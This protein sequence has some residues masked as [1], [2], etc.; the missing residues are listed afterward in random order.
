MTWTKY[1][2]FQKVRAVFRNTKHLTVHGTLVLKGFS[3]SGL[4]FTR[5]FPDNHHS[6]PT[7]R[8]LSRASVIFLVLILLRNLVQPQTHLRLLRNGMILHG[9]QMTQCWQQ[10]IPGSAKKHHYSKHWTP[11]WGKNLVCSKAMLDRGPQWT[12]TTRLVHGILN[13]DVP[14]W[15]MCIPSLP[16]PKSRAGLDLRWE[17]PDHIESICPFGNWTLH[18][19]GKFNLKEIPVRNWDKTPLNTT[20]LRSWRPLRWGSATE[21]QSQVMTFITY[22]WKQAQ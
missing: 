5:E 6:C 11:N 8:A 21:L 2:S 3:E 4:V 1:T 19:R 17:G 9:R 13:W 15:G 7:E 22:G 14:R 16:G 20:D 18:I 10:L 12:S